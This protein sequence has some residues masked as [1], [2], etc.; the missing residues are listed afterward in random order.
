MFEWHVAMTWGRFEHVNLPLKL[1]LL[2]W[3]SLPQ[4]LASRQAHSNTASLSWVCAYT[5]VG[6]KRRQVHIPSLQESPH[7]HVTADTPPAFLVVSAK[8]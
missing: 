8:D 4:D 3:M 5:L 6:A 2:S 7:L 1:A